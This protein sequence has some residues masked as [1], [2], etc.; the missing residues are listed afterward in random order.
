MLVSICTIT[1]NRRAFIPTLIQCVQHQT[2]KDIE[3]I[4]LDDGTDPIGDLVKNI[5]FVKYIQ[6]PTKHA[7][8]KKRNL[9]HSYC[10]GD[11]LVYMDDDDYY[12]PTRVS[13]AVEKLT[14]SDCLCAGSS[15]IHVYYPHLD[16]IIE[17]GPYHDYHATAATFA[18]KRELLQQT[19][20]EEKA[21]FGEEAYFLKQYTIPMVQLDPLQ[22]ILVVP[23]GQNTV[24]KT[25][26]VHDKNPYLHECSLQMTDFIKEPLLYQFFHDDIKKIPAKKEEFSIRLGNQLLYEKDIVEMLNKQHQYI[27]HL[28]QEIKALKALHPIQE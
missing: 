11:I 7:I 15:I 18:F 19:S 17:F 20:Y 2:Y 3:W 28:T 1:F 14:A 23:H 16:K 27:V 26:I 6:L 4:I 10:S 5:P 9:I 22:V 25:K 13:H 24:D 8:G 12:P 21:S